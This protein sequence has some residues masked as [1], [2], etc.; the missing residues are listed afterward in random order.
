MAVVIMLV[1][2]YYGFTASGGPAGVGE[3][4]G[5]AVR[6]SLIIAAFVTV[7]DLAGR[8][9]P[10]R[11]LQLFRIARMERAG[12]TWPAPGVVDRDAVA[13]VAAVWLTAALFTGTLSR[14]CRS[15]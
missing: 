5:R 15:R 1:H 10:V 14:T 3:A 8:L 7:D 6:T 12:D 2:T 4:V 9:R 13:V 11:Q